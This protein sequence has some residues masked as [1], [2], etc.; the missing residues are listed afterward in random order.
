MLANVYEYVKLSITSGGAL[1][2]QV[3]V[4]GKKWDVLERDVWGVSYV[5]N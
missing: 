1:N 3:S 4:Q 2:G 5:N